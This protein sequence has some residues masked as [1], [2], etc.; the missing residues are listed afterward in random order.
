[1]AGVVF[2]GSGKESSTEQIPSNHCYGLLK[3]TIALKFVNSCNTLP[4]KKG[5]VQQ[6]TVWLSF[7]CTCY[8]G[9]IKICTCKREPPEWKKAN[10][11]YYKGSPTSPRKCSVKLRKPVS[12]IIT[13]RTTHIMKISPKGF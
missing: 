1:M 9:I 8:L 5:I 2:A 6:T 7:R 11:T 10:R 12:L 13:I 4:F 3:I